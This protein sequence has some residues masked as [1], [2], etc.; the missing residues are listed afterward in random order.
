M[1]ACYYVRPAELIY[2]GSIADPHIDL[3]MSAIIVYAI[4]IGVLSIV[5]LWFGIG[6]EELKKNYLV[7]DINCI[8]VKGR[9]LFFS[10]IPD[11]IVRTWAIKNVLLIIWYMLIGL[12]SILWCT[13]VAT[14][15]LNSI[16]QAH[17]IIRA[18]RKA[19]IMLYCILIA[20]CN[21][22]LLN[23][24]FRRN[25]QMWKSSGYYFLTMTILFLQ[26]LTFPIYSLQRLFNDYHFKYGIPMNKFAKLS[27][28]INIFVTS[29]SKYCTVNTVY[30]YCHMI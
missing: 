29:V 27:L 20:S 24:T 3:F 19:F 6:L 4:K 25:F 23:G 26:S 17:A 10:L 1:H 16:I 5:T 22:L 8:K 2:F 18:H 11:L 14:A 28:K 13:Y 21:C 15:S 30:S 7:S 12:W 9:D